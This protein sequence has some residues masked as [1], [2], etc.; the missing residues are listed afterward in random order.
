MPRMGV[1]FA[2]GMCFDT[3][4]RGMGDPRVVASPIVR[5]SARPPGLAAYIGS[6]IRSIFYVYFREFTFR[7]CLEKRDGSRNSGSEGGQE[8]SKGGRVPACCQ[9]RGTVEMTS[10]IFQTVSPRTPLNR[11]RCP[12]LGRHACTS[13]EGPTEPRII[14]IIPERYQKQ[15]FVTLLVTFLY[16]TPAKLV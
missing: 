8:G 6:G 13:P 4:W 9:R 14:R 3:G 7:N 11:E 16:R 2:A 15:H 5:R 12:S 1:F 10:A